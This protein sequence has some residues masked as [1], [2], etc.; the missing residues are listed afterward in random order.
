M[1]HYDGILLIISHVCNMS[2]HLYV[3]IYPYIQPPSVRSRFLAVGSDPDPDVRPS[4]LNSAT[5]SLT[6]SSAFCQLQ[7]L[8]AGSSSRCFLQLIIASIRRC[9]RRRD[10]H[11]SPRGLGLITPPISNIFPKICAAFPAEPAALFA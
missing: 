8:M 9:W 7:D 10:I 11:A 1:N 5:E 4:C 3:G 2:K 6:S